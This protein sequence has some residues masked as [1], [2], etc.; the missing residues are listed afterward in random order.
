[1]KRNYNYGLLKQKIKDEFGTYSNFAKT[2]GI[3]NTRLSLMLNGKAIWPP[4]LIYD[5][6]EYLGIF[7]QIEDYFF[8][9]KNR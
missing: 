4:D 6:A 8:T 3:T 5:S 9:L 1:M 7:G 2:L